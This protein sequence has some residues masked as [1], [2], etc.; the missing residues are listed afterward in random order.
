M[1]NDRT[2]IDPSTTSVT[3]AAS[4][5]HALSSK[6]AASDAPEVTALI[7]VESGRAL[8]WPEV[9]SAITTIDPPVALAAT[10]TIDMVLTILAALERNQALAIGPRLSLEST[11]TATRA[12]TALAILTSGSS[13]SPRLIEHRA[14]ALVAHAQASALALDSRVGDRWLIAL[15][16]AHVSGLGP[17]IR[18]L[19]FRRSV[20]LM[21][22]FDTT[23]FIAAIVS[24]QITLTSLVP[25][26]LS[27]LVKQCWRPPAHL[28]HVLIGGAACSAQ[29][30]EQAQ[31]LGIPITICY[32]MTETF[33]HIVIN[34][35][36][37]PGIEARTDKEGVLSI[38]GPISTTWPQWLRTQDLATLTKTPNGIQVDILSRADDVI[39]SGGENVSP[40]RVRDALIA[41]PLINDAHVIGINDPEWGQR[42]AAMI[43]T[44]T[45][46]DTNKLDGQLRSSLAGHERPRRYLVV[47]SIPRLPSGKPDSQTIAKQLAD[48]L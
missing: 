11:A 26:M 22:K 30:R 45:D 35:R 38:R 21:K 23:R 25:T 10:N 15:P 40:T 5:A 47:R 48:E 4:I 6:A 37:L 3:S 7:D 42:V 9:S 46:V 28:R 44:Q 13:A 32:G 34:G 19:V 8:S 41:H 12:D 24:H 16:I 1:T 43:A 17:I 14:S 18:A 31:N 2:A 36:L 27:R 39:I 20:A 29:L 33:S